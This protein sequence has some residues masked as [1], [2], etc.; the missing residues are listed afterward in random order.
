MT[1]V[2]FLDIP[3]G[4]WTGNVIVCDYRKGKW[5]GEKKQNQNPL[6]PKR[7]SFSKVLRRTKYSGCR[8]SEP[9]AIGPVQ[10]S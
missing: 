6:A 8:L 4:D 3:G 7:K 5:G 2:M 9:F 10:F 1:L